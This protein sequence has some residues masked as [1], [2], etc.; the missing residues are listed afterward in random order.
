VPSFSILAEPSVAVVQ[1]NASKHGAGEAAKAYLEYLYAPE[2][3]RIAAK[4]YYRPRKPQDADPK[5][6][7]RFAK[8]ELVTIE[9]AFGG[10]HAAQE[11]FFADGGVFDQIYLPSVP[12]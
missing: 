11:K 1:T 10:W 12:K 5:D 4:H 8:L 7:A 2:G 3:Q 6:V 9:D